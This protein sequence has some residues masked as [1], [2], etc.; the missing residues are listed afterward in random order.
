MLV[1]YETFNSG[2]HVCICIVFCP[3]KG[4]LGLAKAINKCN[5]SFLTLFVEYTSERFREDGSSR[6]CRVLNTGEYCLTCMFQG[7]N[8]GT[9]SSARASELTCKSLANKVRLNYTHVSKYGW[10]TCSLTHFCLALFTRSNKT[11]KTC[12]RKESCPQVRK[13]K[14]GGWGHVYVSNNTLKPKG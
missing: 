9:S 13:R 8:R 5:G 4:R 3:L 2:L 11:Q 6:H 10:S 12:N 14:G 7:P 1:R